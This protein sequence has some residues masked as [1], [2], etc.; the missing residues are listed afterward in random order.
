MMLKGIT[1]SW[2]EIEIRRST[3]GLPSVSERRGG[4]FFH[5]PE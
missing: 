5:M 3:S 4:A 1:D 2:V